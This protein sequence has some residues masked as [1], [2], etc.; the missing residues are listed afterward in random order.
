MSTENQVWSKVQGYIRTSIGR[1][2]PTKSEEHMG[3]AY[4]LFRK[5]LPGYDPAKG[6]IEPYLARRIVLE[7]KKQHRMGGVVTPPTT[8]LISLAHH[9][10][11][12]LVISAFEPEAL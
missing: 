4:I 7:L 9:A 2:F 12:S 10:K 3:E 8:V 11:H 6:R 5:L 1:A